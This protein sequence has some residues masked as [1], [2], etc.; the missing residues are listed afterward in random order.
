MLQKKLLK[1]S[2]SI[3]VTFMQLNVF[4]VYIVIHIIHQI[5]GWYYVLYNMHYLY[6]LASI[7]NIKL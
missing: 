2:K 5:L 4:V 7:Y 6:I 3:E 1:E